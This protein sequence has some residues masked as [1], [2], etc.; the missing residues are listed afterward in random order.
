MYTL[1][2]DI[3]TVVN[4]YIF[5]ITGKKDHN[6]QFKLINQ[7]PQLTKQLV[8]CSSKVPQLIKQLV[9]WSSHTITS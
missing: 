5:Y 3:K 9:M 2:I 7:V 6:F 1:T 4:L 8:M